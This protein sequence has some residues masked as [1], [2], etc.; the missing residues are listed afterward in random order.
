MTPVEMTDLTLCFPDTGKSC[1]ACCPP[2]RPAGYEHIQH[3]NIIKRMLRE[4]NEAFEKH[5]GEKIPITGFSCWALG[6][7]DKNHRL[8]GCLLHP[9]QNGGIDLRYR[10]GYGEKCE[11]EFCPEAKVFSG[12]ALDDKEFWLHLAD[13]LDSFSY[14]SRKLNPLFDMMNW[15]GNLLGSI[16]SNEGYRAFTKK[17][18]FQ[19]YPLLSACNPVKP[20]VYLIKWLV[21]R[22]GTHILKSRTLKRAFQIFSARIS[23]KLC[24]AGRQSNPPLPAFR[25]GPH[26]GDFEGAFTHQLD[27]DPHFL[28][29]LRLSAHVTR[30]SRE[31]A[32]ALKNLVDGELEEFRQ[33]MGSI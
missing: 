18:F 22:E 32:L 30:T 16:A 24:Q 4:N 7:L 19:S 12:L 20:N 29:F 5:E 9:A 6:Y 33:S 8:I 23:R 28:D 14:S 31:D 26:R 17:S 10:T 27:L 3:R 2:I 11:R 15:G 21:D 13:G 25:Q 1:F